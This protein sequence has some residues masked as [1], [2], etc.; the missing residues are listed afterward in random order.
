[1]I[2]L[3]PRSGGRQTG[4]TCI[5]KEIQNAGTTRPIFENPGD[6]L[7]IIGLLWKQTH[8]LECRHGQ[9][10]PEFQRGALVRQGPT[11]P[12][13]P[14]PASQ[15]LPATTSSGFKTPMG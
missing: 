5:G 10:K 13:R 15:P 8:M 11:I 12:G 6:K 9:L 3:G 14:W 4:P 1:M 2:D 7:P